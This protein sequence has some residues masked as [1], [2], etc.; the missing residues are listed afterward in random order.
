MIQ[1]IDKLLEALI[2]YYDF[3]PERLQTLKI[4]LSFIAG[5]ILTLVGFTL[6]LMLFR[7]L[8]DEPVTGSLLL[9]FLT[10]T[11]IVVLFLDDSRDFARWKKSQDTIER[12]RKKP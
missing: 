9:M 6:T 12:F 3:Y 5:G 8:F 4:T 2:R 11:F 10:A 7:W 1:L